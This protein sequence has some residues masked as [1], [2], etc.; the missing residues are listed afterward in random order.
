MSINSEI[1]PGLQRVSG[2]IIIQETR[3]DL[4]FPVTISNMKRQLRG[5]DRKSLKK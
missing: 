1:F 5:F 2:K 3:H 4:K